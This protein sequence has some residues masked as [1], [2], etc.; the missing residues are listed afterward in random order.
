MKVQYK[1]I[2]KECYWEGEKIGWNW[3]RTRQEILA[4]FN[5]WLS[6]NPIKIISISFC[7]KKSIEMETPAFLIL[8][9]FYEFQK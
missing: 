7:Y 5:L 1:F 6:E 8:E 2:R 4:E 9:V 3:E